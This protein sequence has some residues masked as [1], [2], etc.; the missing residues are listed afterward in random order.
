MTLVT[1]EGTTLFRGYCI[2]CDSTRWG[3]IPGQHQHPDNP[4]AEVVTNASCAHCVDPVRF[5]ARAY[6][7]ETPDGT[8]KHRERVSQLAAAYDDR[9][10]DPSLWVFTVD[11]PTVYLPN[12]P[13]GEAATVVQIQDREL[14]FRRRRANV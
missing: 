11:V 4:Y 7:Q 6:L 13:W 12:F 5:N 3:Y 8:E 1:S 10:S 9:S 14:E 2:G